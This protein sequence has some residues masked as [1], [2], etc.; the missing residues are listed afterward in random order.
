MGKK[1]IYNII[2]ILLSVI[3]IIFLKSSYSMA[4]Y[5]LDDDFNATQNNNGEKAIALYMKEHGTFSI[6][7]KKIINKTIQAGYNNTIHESNATCVSE[8]NTA[9]GLYYYKI[10]YICDIFPDKVEIYNDKNSVKTSKL[11]VFQK[12]A[13]ILVNG[14]KNQG[15]LMINGNQF[16][17]YLEANKKSLGIPDNVE[18]GKYG[19]DDG[20]IANAHEVEDYKQQAEKYKCNV[21][22]GDST[23]T[24]INQLGPFEVN[25]SDDVI[26]DEITVSD[27]DFVSV[28]V[29]GKK[30]TTKKDIVSKIKGG[31]EFYINI[32]NDKKI[33]SKKNIKIKTKTSKNYYKAR[34]ILLEA[35]NAGQNL[36]IFGF[37]SKPI[38]NTLTLTSKVGKLRLLKTDGTDYVYGTT[39]K[40]YKASV[41][42]AVVGDT[43]EPIQVTCETGTTGG[44]YNYYK[45]NGTVKIKDLNSPI[46]SNNATKLVVG[47]SNLNN[48]YNGLV[49]IAGLPEGW[50][51]VEE[52]STDA[53]HY[54]SQRNKLV[55][56]NST[57]VLSENYQLKEVNNSKIDQ[58][59]LQYAIKV[60]TD[61]MPKT[62]WRGDSQEIQKIYYTVY[63]KNPSSN[64]IKEVES[65]VDF[66]K[67]DSYNQKRTKIVSAIFKLRYK[68]ILKNV[69][70]NGKTLEEIYRNISQESYKQLLRNYLQE[71]YKR[72]LDKDMP[73]KHMKNVYYSRAIGITCIDWINKKNDTG[74]L[75]IKKVDNDNPNVPIKGIGFKI[76][77]VEKDNWIKINQE[78]AISY[79]PFEDQNT[80]LYTDGDGIIQIDNLP[81]GKYKVYET[82][83]PQELQN[84][85]E[86]TETQRIK[87]YDQIY[88]DVKA[89]I[90]K[91]A[92]G[93][94]E[95]TITSNDLILTAKNRKTNGK[96][97]IQKQDSSTKKNLQG[98]GFKI[99]SKEKQGWLN[100]DDENKVTDYVDFNKAKL[101]VTDSNGLVQIN[102][103][104]AGKY[105]IV[106]TNLGPYS[107]IYELKTFTFNGMVITGNIVN[108]DYEVKN[109][110]SGQ[111]SVVVAYNDRVY[112]GLTGFVWQDNLAHY[113]DKT[114]MTRNNIYDYDVD[115]K[116]KG[117]TVKLMDKT[118]PTVPVKTTKTD[119]NGNYEFS[120]V[121]L[122]KLS[123][124]YVEFE[125]DGLIYQSV[126][127]VQ[128]DREDGSKANEDENIRG[129]FNNSFANINA[130]NKVVFNNKEIELKYNKDAQGL[131]TLDNCCK[132]NTIGKKVEIVSST[133]DFDIY[134]NTLITKLN[135]KDYYDTYYSNS[136]IIENIN[137]GLYERE[138][139]DLSVKKDV[140]KADVSIN[141][142]YYTYN[143]NQ[144]LV[145]DKIDTTLGVQFQNKRTE[146]YNLPIYKAD[147]AYKSEDDSKNLD[148]K[149]TYKIALINEAT[150]IYS[151]VNSIS[152]YFSSQYQYTGKIGIG[153]QDEI[154]KDISGD[155]K[156]TEGGNKEGY[157]C[158]KFENLG[159]KVPPIS[160]GSNVKYLYI[161]FKL[162]KDEYYK[163]G[164][165][166][167]LNLENIVEIAS[168][169]NYQ[170]AGFQNSYAGIDKDSIPD[171]VQTN[172]PQTNIKD[173]S[174]W[175][176]DMDKALGLQV[177][178]AGDRQITGV[179]FEDA[180][181][182]NENKE[183]LGNG[184]Y[185]EGE[186]KIS[187]VTVNLVEKE[188]ENSK[189]VKSVQTNNGEYTISGFMPSK[190]YYIEFEWGND[191]YSVNDYKGTI[192]TY[193]RSLNVES[194]EY[195]YKNDLTNRWSDAMDNWDLRQ[196]IDK[197]DSKVTK[198]TSTTDPFS[199]GIE[200]VGEN[201]YSYENKSYVINGVDFGLAERPRQSI[202]IKKE[203]SRVKISDASSRILVD[204]EIVEDENGN[205]KFK[206]DVKYAV[207]TDKSKI[208]PLGKVK[209]EIDNE[210]FPLTVDITYKITVSNTSE[211]DYNS[212]S[213][214]KYG[215]KGT[216]EQKVKIKPVG[217]YDYLDSKLTVDVQS[218]NKEG[219]TNKVI[220]KEE[221]LQTVSETT[222]IEQEYENYKNWKDT[223]ENYY[224]KY[225]N[226]ITG[227]K[228]QTIFEQW[229]S[230][231]VETTTKNKKIANK[232]IID[233]ETLSKEIAAGQT[234]EATF[235]AQGTLSS[236]DEIKL[237]NDAEITKVERNG[238][239][240][241]KT[242][243]LNTPI[244][245]RA[246]EVTIT[247][248]TGE[249]KQI[250]PWIIISI[251]AMAVLAIGIIF[252]KKK[253]LK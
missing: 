161:E 96:I 30:Y 179:V 244:Y 224:T 153:T 100:T 233:F 208:A 184:K 175:E 212:E 165:F 192:R 140:Y 231:T 41:N 171:S 2:F 99:Y 172:I 67:N 45:N 225:E 195:W 143:Y 128:F 13:A 139:P 70:Y 178:D 182:V 186:E 101:F 145:E 97:I 146:N 64:F 106:E 157:K 133:G 75:T 89:K 68:D 82:K 228:Y 84:I 252:I 47:K 66:N 81:K 53:N 176:D 247:P 248:P 77:S 215:T 134:S 130:N 166:I 118:N 229:K 219:V 164:E 114:N 116:I 147:A 39:F 69:K 92:N 29:D 52:V 205:K 58:V 155:V 174:T 7:P 78:G 55:Y 211:L 31:K 112:I 123:Y 183:R 10:R 191:K 246:E 221:Y 189:I 85:Y 115:Y 207:Y 61:N 132:R 170:D 232:N 240:G 235:N 131:V 196:E 23:K 137:L 158:Y 25:F 17:K 227:M 230:N 163:N 46:D 197:D 238:Q 167:E 51:F 54:I 34:L 214:Y 156:V 62:T 162:P 91:D 19:K 88:Y 222:I 213:Y 154:T 141:G 245:D 169:S 49:D 151:Q 63:S 110:S 242:T 190:N 117:I 120:K 87:R 126:N 206:D 83:I 150:N 36:A 122:N 73:H 48:G 149:V 144:N 4:K 94:D 12:L 9:T 138:K 3:L 15:D 204:A 5:D 38:T 226:E 239:Y 32:K 103:V 42:S 8:S 180:T 168:Y 14:K 237:T 40:L 203:V 72:G 24:S 113:N 21:V 199:I 209:A 249:N 201:S 27:A 119:D 80:E 105:M 127:Y 125:Y 104:L 251:S 37:E 76:Y 160:Q 193:E 98:I 74:S 202:E 210:L 152:E 188:N 35:Y 93:N 33:T 129:N 11:G 220:S 26:I 135:L 95:I 65:K 6:D 177:R 181:I 121:L 107:D 173:V 253:I 124:Y 109:D 43:L 218:L 217:V 148:V 111:N 59:Y 50:Y 223:D 102:N 216:E 28:T 243:A 56:C 86:I 57:S 18:V 187:G 90:I 250:T 142:M 200:L 136:D 241:R 20:S 1:L 44:R 79:V 16:S 185:D 159:I 22:K 71:A 60:I 194:S 236:T 198:M 234:N 108:N